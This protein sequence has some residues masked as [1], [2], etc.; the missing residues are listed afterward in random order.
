MCFDLTNRASFNALPQ[1]IKE[2][3]RHINTP[4]VLMIVGT[5][6]DL[7]CEEEGE[8]R[9]SKRQVTTAEAADLAAGHEASYI[10]TSALNKLNV[11]ET[12]QMMLKQVCISIDAAEDADVAT[13][14]TSLNLPI[15]HTFR[16]SP[17]ASFHRGDGCC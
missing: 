12:L 8:K 15:R 4:H 2:V 13:Y 6:R 5:K 14:Q 9:P 11:D 3:K 7:C 10:E 1:W 17:T 16:P